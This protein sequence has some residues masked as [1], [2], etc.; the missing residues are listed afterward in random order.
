MTRPARREAE[1]SSAVSS[2]E[3]ERASTRPSNKNSYLE[4]AKAAADGTCEFT[5]K[6]FGAEAADDDHA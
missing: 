1:S 5:G 4:I 2:V 6:M 3:S